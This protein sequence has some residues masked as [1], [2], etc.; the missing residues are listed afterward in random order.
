MLYIVHRLWI[1][2][3]N[4]HIVIELKYK[5]FVDYRYFAKRTLQLFKLYFFMHAAKN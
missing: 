4:R 1:I 5:T 3:F 2:D